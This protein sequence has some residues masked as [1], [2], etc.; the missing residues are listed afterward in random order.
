MAM[1]IPKPASVETLVQM[2]YE[3]PLLSNED[4][5]KIFPKIG[6]TT[7][8]NLKKLAREEAN[9]QGMMQYNSRLVWTKPAYVAWG[10]N[11]EDL[12]KDLSNLRRISGKKDDRRE[13]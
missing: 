2:Y 7:V 3:T 9:K 4:I 6:T 11:I 13:E 10:L 1:N 12:K 8:Q 5:K